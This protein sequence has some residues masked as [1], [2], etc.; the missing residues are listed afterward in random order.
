M[1]IDWTKVMDM[2]PSLLNL[3]D[4]VVRDAQMLQI[5]DNKVTRANSTKAFLHAVNY[6]GVFE[7]N[8]WD[9]VRSALWSYMNHPDSSGEASKALFAALVHGTL[10]TARWRHVGEGPQEAFK[11]AYNASQLGLGSLTY[12]DST[13]DVVGHFTARFAAAYSRVAMEAVKTNVEEEPTADILQAMYFS[14]AHNIPILGE[15][16]K[17]VGR[18]RVLLCGR[19]SPEAYH[20]LHTMVA[21]DI[22]NEI[23]C[24]YVVIYSGLIDNDAHAKYLAE[25]ARSK[26]PMFFVHNRSMSYRMHKELCT[27][28]SKNYW[29]GGFEE[30]NLLLSYNRF[31]PIDFGGID[32]G[33]YNVKADRKGVY[34]GLERTPD[35]LHGIDKLVEMSRRSNLDVNPKDAQEAEAILGIAHG[36]V[37]RYTVPYTHV[38]SPNVLLDGLIAR[39][40][41]VVN[42][43]DGMVVIQPGQRVSDWLDWTK[44]DRGFLCVPKRDFEVANEMLH[45]WL[46]TLANL[47][48]FV[49]LHV[50]DME[51]T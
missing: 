47:A 43:R 20:L 15:G 36:C 6:A 40:Q 29:S 7:G 13:E 26:I 45:S 24:G 48:V 22:K 27:V 16:L 38:D 23:Y 3:A 17:D 11:R 33:I 51:L 4:K 50:E 46:W 31:F 9:S 1:K 44:A 37:T 35:V 41:R 19:P 21:D 34:V 10:E 12:E 42:A 18:C 8:I 14:G 32:T 2:E 30:A 28:L 39:T 5:N 25:C 49:P